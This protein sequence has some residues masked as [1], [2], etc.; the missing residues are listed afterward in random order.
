M[1]T[2]TFPKT[3]IEPILGHIY[4]YGFDIISMTLTD[5]IYTMTLNGTITE[6]EFEP[7]HTFH[8]LEIVT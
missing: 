6:D 8:N 4:A 7:L 1:N 3:E 2:Y 5:D